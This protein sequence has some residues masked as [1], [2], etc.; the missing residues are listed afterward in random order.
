M[1]P[2]D[3]HTQVYL[4]GDSEFYTYLAMHFGKT[5]KSN[6]SK[7]FCA[8]TDIVF[9]LFPTP[10]LTHLSLPRFIGSNVDDGLGYA[11]PREQAQVMIDCLFVAG[12]ET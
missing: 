8:W 1:H 9:R 5:R 4:L 10:D 3:W 7:H 11:I 12:L 6:S 2:L